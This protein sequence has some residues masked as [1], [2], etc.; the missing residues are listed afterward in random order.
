[1]E[2]RPMSAEFAIAL[3]VIA[4]GSMWA[5]WKLGFEAGQNDIL[6]KYQEYYRKRRASEQEQKE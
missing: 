4:F 6:D 2:D 1:M 3:A 5:C